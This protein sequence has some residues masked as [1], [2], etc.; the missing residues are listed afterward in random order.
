MSQPKVKTLEWHELDLRYADIRIHAQ[1]AISRLVRSIQ[2]H[3]L[4]IPILVVPLGNTE[5]GKRWVVID[6]YLRIAALQTLRHDSIGVI[7]SD[8][9]MKEALIDLYH[10]NTSRVWEAYEEAKLV[11]TLISEHQLSQT[12]VAQQLGKSKSWVSY[13]LQLLQELPEFIEQAI[14]QGALSTWTT[15]RIILPFAR[16]NSEGAKK[17]V[18][19]L[20]IKSHASR[21][22]QAYYTH[23]LSSNRQ[24]RK[25]M[26]DEPQHFFKAYAFQMKSDTVP[27]D[28]L[29]PEEAWES[30]LMLCLSKLK[31]LETILPAVFYPNQAPSECSMLSEPFLALLKQVHQL[32]KSIEESHHV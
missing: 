24:T 32:Q 22:I 28:K 12:E 20:E 29:A 11:Q 5:S 4:L 27:C 8:H 10:Q 2:S 3:G 13:R 19:Y 18:K 6:G 17:L 25:N 21:D 14:R 26:L 9:T 7:V 23:Y 15:Q 30:I 1:T 16:A 31:R